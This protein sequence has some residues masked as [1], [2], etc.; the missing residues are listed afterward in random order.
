MFLFSLCPPFSLNIAW[1]DHFDITYYLNRVNTDIL[2]KLGVALGIAHSR[3]QTI[4]L[5]SYADDMVALWLLRMDQVMER[6][7]PTWATLEKAMRHET[8]GMVG[9]AN[10]IKR[11]KLNVHTCS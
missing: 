2:Q 9:T 7:G 6:G 4:Q 3:L 1:R 11:D 10:D 5:P 8:V